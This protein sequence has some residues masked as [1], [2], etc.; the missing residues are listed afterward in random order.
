MKKLQNILGLAVV[1]ALVMTTATA[2]NEEPHPQDISVAKFAKAAAGIEWAYARCVAALWDN[3]DALTVVCEHPFAF[4]LTWTRNWLVHDDKEERDVY[5][6]SALSRLTAAVADQSELAIRCAK[7]GADSTVAVAIRCKP[8]IDKLNDAVSMLVGNPD[9]DAPSDPECTDFADVAGT[10]PDAAASSSDPSLDEYLDISVGA[11]A[12]AQAYIA[13]N[14]AAQLDARVATICEVEAEINR[15]M[16]MLLKDA[17]LA[18]RIPVKSDAHPYASLARVVTTAVEDLLKTIHE[19]STDAADRAIADTKVVIETIAHT[20]EKT[21]EVTGAIAKRARARRLSPEAV[22]AALAEVGISRADFDKCALAM[23]G[24][25]ATGDAES[26]HEC[27]PII[28][29]HARWTKLVE[30]H[31]GHLLLDAII[32]D[33][34]E[35]AKARVERGAEL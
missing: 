24:A 1:M 5:S 4:P 15:N 19:G 26:K 25:K 31:T 27:D 35:Q 22:T 34:L 16:T 29:G 32:N 23:H 21:A 3:V 6:H 12:F 14:Q 18:P 17:I 13:C 10:W 9:P 11:N 8:D 7:D 2:A 28:Q 20:I 33:L 30:Q